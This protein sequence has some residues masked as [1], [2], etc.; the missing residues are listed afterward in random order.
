MLELTAAR[1]VKPGQEITP[2]E[3]QRIGRATGHYGRLEFRQ[4][5]PEVLRRDPYLSIAPARHD[6]LAKC[7]PQVPEGLVE[8]PAGVPVV[9][10]GPQQCEKRVPAVEVARPGNGEVREKS[11]ALRCA[12]TEWRSSPP[13]SRRA[14]VPSAR[15]S[16]I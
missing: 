1:D 7:K 2:V 8:R 9:L 6:L 11:D 3:P 10:L 14:S 16:I 4:V 5:A 12:R 13:E 15:S